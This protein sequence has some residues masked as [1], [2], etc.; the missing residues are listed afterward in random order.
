MILLKTIG[1]PCLVFF[2]CNAS[3]TMTPCFGLQFFRFIRTTFGLISILG[4]T[5]DVRLVVLFGCIEHVCPLFWGT[6]PS[7]HLFQLQPS[8]TNCVADKFEYN[9]STN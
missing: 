3:Q 7:L 5:G 1:T 6:T 9:Q 8:S 4:H 2:L